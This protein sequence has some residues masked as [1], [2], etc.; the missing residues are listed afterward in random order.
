ME[1]K[2]KDKD[3]QMQ[4]PVDPDSRTENPL[5]KVDPDLHKKKPKG[6]DD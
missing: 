2:P 3:K 4:K 6:D 1:E 5:D